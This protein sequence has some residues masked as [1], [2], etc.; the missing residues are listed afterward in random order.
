MNDVAEKAGVSIATVSRVL[1]GR[2]HSRISPWTRDAVMAAAKALNYHID[3]I[4]RALRVQSTASLGLVVPNITNPFFPA[5]IQA[6]EA[7]GRRSSW[8]MVLSDAQDDPAVEREVTE[9]LVARRVDALLISPCDRIRSRKTIL[10]LA[11]SL[12][13]VQLDRSCT[14]KVDHVGV[15]HV[16]AIGQV[17][18]HLTAEGRTR[19]AFLGVHSSEWPAHQ[20]EVAFRRWARH[21]FPQAPVLLGESTLAW[22]SDAVTKAL[23]DD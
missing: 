21:H 16:D 4:G 23:T 10:R 2:P 17:L 3:P 14:S 22:G 5:L 8:S 20:R 6:V 7:A 1:N 19:L 13:V 15:D 9:L 18:A 12:P 11:E